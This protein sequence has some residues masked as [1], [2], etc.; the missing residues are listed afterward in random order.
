[1]LYKNKQKIESYGMDKSPLYKSKP[2]KKLVRVNSNRV[3]Y[4]DDDLLEM[5][6]LKSI[7]SHFPPRLYV[8]EY[9]KEIYS[10]SR[11]D[12]GKDSTADMDCSYSSNRIF[13]RLPKKGET[14]ESL[15][16]HTKRVKQKKEQAEEREMN[17]RINEKKRIEQA[18]LSENPDALAELPHITPK[19]ISDEIEIK[20]K[21]GHFYHMRVAFYPCGIYDRELGRI[22]GFKCESAGFHTDSQD[23][24][25]SSHHDSSDCRTIEEGFKAFIVYWWGH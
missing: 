25:I 12:T 11:Y 20:T 6:T 24:L 14:K 19:T 8:E 13:L 3:L 2:G 23:G 17:R 15:A 18:A 10:L 22:N 16:L 1:M 4:G 21:A 9:P 5:V 7:T